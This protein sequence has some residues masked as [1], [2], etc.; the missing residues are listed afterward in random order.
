[1][2]LESQCVV[3]ME[4]QQTTLLGSDQLQ[5][6]AARPLR[7]Y[8]EK[9]RPRRR[10]CVASYRAVVQGMPVVRADAADAA[11][12]QRGSRNGLDTKT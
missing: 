10:R 6:D 8:R 3:Q 12:G 7:V 9:W 1:M 11:A 2:E 5:L 4:G